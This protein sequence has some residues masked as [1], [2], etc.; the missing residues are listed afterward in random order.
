MYI[1]LSRASLFKTVIV[2]AIV[3]SIAFLIPFQIAEA[4]G[5]GGGFAFSFVLSFIASV[6]I[7]VAFG[8]PPIFGD[9][10][11]STLANEGIS[12]AVG[13]ISITTESVMNF[14]LSQMIGTVGSEFVT[15]SGK[16]SDAGSSAGG[17]NVY[18][19]SSGLSQ[20]ELG[21]EANLSGTITNNGTEDIVGSFTNRFQIF[22]TSV[23]LDSSQDLAQGNP[24]YATVE[25]G[26]PAG[27]T[28]TVTARWVVPTTFNPGQYFLRLCTNVS[29]SVSESNT[30]NNC[31]EL[32]S[33]TVVEPSG[34]GG[35]QSSLNVVSPLARAALFFITPKAQAIS[36][37]DLVSGL[38]T[39]F[40]VPRSAPQIVLC[41][42]GYYF[43]DGVHRCIP[44]GYSSCKFLGY[45]DRVCPPGSFC[46]I[47][48]RCESGTA[49]QNCSGGY[50]K[51]CQ[52][53]AN[54][55]GMTSTGFG[56]CNGACQ[57]VM[58]AET[59]CAVPKITLEASP[60]LVNYK[61]RCTIS[62]TLSS[63]RSCLLTGPGVSEAIYTDRPKGSV[64]TPPLENS[65]KYVMSCRNGSVVR[66]EKSI[67]CNL[68]P[69]FRE[70]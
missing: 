3:F 15:G 58:P 55:C 57:A 28:V 43:L 14:G 64:R 5:G 65:S 2:V 56:S 67:T 13:A 44:E 21:G 48:G 4:K 7:S 42:F 25:G 30:G 26:I 9:A 1:S 51:P 45:P 62:W 29:G 38:P 19:T 60:R 16:T 63:Y 49:G 47:D 17:Y 32:Q 54:S 37:A 36:W 18:V 10:F 35:G 46:T 31:G 50:N 33:F 12:A 8:L 22:A 68:N 27:S 53:A 70:I 52:S 6:A 20:I 61:T 40:P 34:S 69:R 41:P 11:L 24:I 66:A 59:L 39:I 23:L